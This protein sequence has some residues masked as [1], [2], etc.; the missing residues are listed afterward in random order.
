MKEAVASGIIATIYCRHLQLASA[1]LCSH[2][3]MRQLLSFSQ[4]LIIFT[5]ASALLPRHTKRVSTSDSALLRSVGGILLF[6]LRIPL[7]FLFFSLHLLPLL[8]HLIKHRMIDQCTKIG[9]KRYPDQQRQRC[10][11]QVMC[12]N[13]RYH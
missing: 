5:N 6:F 13:K 12:Q 1:I 9:R 10:K 11:T 2:A 8:Y 4:V 3:F 7:F